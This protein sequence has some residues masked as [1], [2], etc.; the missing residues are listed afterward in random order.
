MAH[1]ALLIA[2][3]GSTKTSWCLLYNEEIRI[4]TQGISPYFL[5]SEEIEKV[6]QGELLARLPLAPGQVSRVYFYGTGLAS[7]EKADA[8]KAILSGIFNHAKMEINHDLTGAARA[9]C[10]HEKG[11][12]CILGTGSGSCYFDG[13]TIAES[14]PG[15]G[16]ILGDEGSGAYLGKLLIQSYLYQELDEALK[17]RFEKKYHPS[18]TEILKKI[19][20]E[21]Y[22]NRYLA[23]YARFLGDN[24]A[25]PEAKNII[26]KGITDFLLRHVKSYEESA[27]LPVHFVGGVAKAFEKEI[28]YICRKNELKPGRILKN[29]LEG[30]IRFHI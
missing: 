21:P 20:Q 18:K 6:I 30:L 8:M 19:Y 16:F 5:S 22:P 10:G 9:L 26:Y 11:L 25:H 28:V 3:S 1:D 13:M 23:S 4:G 12:A 15:L 24:R 7:P 17:E 2:D 29:P 27:Y 14:R